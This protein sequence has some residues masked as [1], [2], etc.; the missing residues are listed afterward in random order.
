MEASADIRTV[1]VTLAYG[2]TDWLTLSV[3]VPVERRGTAV[4]T[5]H[6]AGGTLGLNP[7]VEGNAALLE[8]LGEEY[9]ALGASALFPTRDS[10]LGIALQQR[11]RSLLGD[12][13]QLALARNP[14]LLGAANLAE[15]TPEEQAALALGSERTEYLLGDVQPAIRVR[16]VRGPPEGAEGAVRGP[17]WRSALGIRGR[18]PTGP[19]WGGGLL[20]EIPSEHGHAG[21]GVDLANELYLTGRLTLD[22]AGSLDVRLPATVQRRAFAADRPFPGDTALRTLRR[23]PGT[24]LAVAISP[25]FGLTDE[26]SLAGRYG[27]LRQGETRL[28]GEEGIVAGPTEPLG[29]WTGHAVGF[30]ARYSTLAACRRA[31][32]APAARARARSETCARIALRSHTPVAAQHAG[33]LRIATRPR[34]RGPCPPADPPRWRCGRRA[35]ACAR[36]GGVRARGDLRQVGD[37]EHLMA[38][39]HLRIFSP[40]CSATRPPIPASTSSKTSVGTASRRARIVLSASMTRDSS[41]PEATNASGAA[42]SRGSA[43]RGTRPPPPRRRRLRQRQRRPRS[44]SRH[45]QLGEH[46]VHLL[47]QPL[48][49]FGA[50]RSSAAAS[51]SSSA[52]ASSSSPLQPAQLELRGVQQVQLGARAT[53]ELQHLVQR[54]P[55]LE[56]SR[57]IRS[58]RGGSRRAA[59]GRARRWRR[60]ARA[61]RP[62]P[63]ARSRRC[64]R[65]PRRRLRRVD[66]EEL[67]Q[68]APQRAER[69]PANPRRRRA[70][71]GA[72]RRATAAP[73]SARAG[74]P[75]PPAPPPRPAS[76]APRPR[77]RRPGSAGSPRAAAA[78]R[79]RASSA[80]I[81][82]RRARSAR[83]APTRARSSSCPAYASRMARCSSRRSSVWCSCCPCR[84]TSTRPS[85]PSSAAVVG[86]P[87]IQARLR[88]STATSRLRTSSRPPP[89]ARARPASAHDPSRPPT[90]KTPSTEA[91]SAPART[92]SAEARSPSSSD[93]AP[94][95]IDFPAPVSP[96]ST[97]SPGPSRTVSWSISAKLRIRSSVSMGE[98]KGTCEVR[99]TMC[100]V[101]STKYGVQYDVG[102]CG[103]RWKEGRRRPGRRHF[104]LRTPYFADACLQRSRSSASC[105]TNIGD[106]RGPRPRGGRAPARAGCRAPPGE[107]APRPRPRPAP[108]P[109]APPAPRP[110]TRRPAAGRPARAAGRRSRRWGAACPGTAR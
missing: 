104:V 2:A 86:E 56:R 25:R 9:G 51:G 82:P 17:A 18:I 10:P 67:V 52:A 14:L 76:S 101:R 26:I 22:A 3:T 71:R 69:R 68:R 65:A 53:A 84:S 47:G 95:M 75:P 44:A 30:G 50:W 46:G 32:P 15:L 5:R 66:A 93:S 20:L 90:S 58:C 59:P 40:T 81:S 78:S 70:P 80:S 23:E 29:P 38:P 34:A 74:A 7:D 24:R 103:L 110:R 57:K 11:V 91:R 62:A 61:A 85:S 107:A 83:A 27:L 105:R 16:L 72:R 100:E 33:D 54:L 108:R 36:A 19:R 13:V 88:P 96:V 45:P 94:T 35:R 48:A 106:P 98:V 37:R 4:Q 60:S 102:K 42:R 63:G 64:R 79:R 21:W 92:T 97:F 39:G 77:S 43:T 55:Y 6:L 99:C 41:P 31:G 73:R 109:G 89:P 49:A 28:T 12:T 87:L 8:R 1:P